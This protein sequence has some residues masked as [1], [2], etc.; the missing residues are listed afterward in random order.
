MC[1]HCWVAGAASDYA[2]AAGEQCIKLDCTIYNKPEYTITY[3]VVQ[4]YYTT[5]SSILLD[6]IRLLYLRI[7]DYDDLLYHSPPVNIAVVD[8]ND[9]VANAWIF[10]TT[11][12]KKKNTYYYSIQYQQ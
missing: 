10:C 7:L 3:I 1:G 8:A 6:H 4:Q 12:H 2:G 9:V 5:I 11:Q